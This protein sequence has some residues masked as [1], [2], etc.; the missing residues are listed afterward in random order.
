MHTNDNMPEGLR[1]V[2]RIFFFPSHYELHNPHTLNLEIHVLKPHGVDHII[3]L[4]VQT[5]HMLLIHLHLV[6]LHLVHILHLVLVHIHRV[7]RG[8]RHYWGSRHYRR[9]RGH[10]VGLNHPYLLLVSV[11]SVAGAG[12]KTVALA[13]VLS[14]AQ[15]V[16]QETT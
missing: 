11:L 13:A 12:T 10:I 14:L 5:T 9:Y 6:H 15:L 4:V 2:R 8:G 7:Y 1:P 3:H 16:T